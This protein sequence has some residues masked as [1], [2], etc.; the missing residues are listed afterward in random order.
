MKKRVQQGK[1]LKRRRN[2]I[3]FL[4]LSEDEQFKIGKLFGY[5]VNIF[6]V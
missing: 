2:Q 5:F 3:D 4:D 6:V 1:L